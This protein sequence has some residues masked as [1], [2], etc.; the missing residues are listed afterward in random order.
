MTGNQFL[1]LKVTLRLLSFFK[2]F[3]LTVQSLGNSCLCFQYQPVCLTVAF[4]YTEKRTD[5]RQRSGPAKGSKVRPARFAAMRSSISSLVVDPVL[6]SA[7]GYLFV[8][9]L[10]SE[11]RQSASDTVHPPRAHSRIKCLT[12]YTRLCLT[13][14]APPFGTKMRSWTDTVCL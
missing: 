10:N 11:C 5:P 2:N 1:Y 9:K 8:L 6:P 7:P 4:S 12:K 3:D 13:V 14:T